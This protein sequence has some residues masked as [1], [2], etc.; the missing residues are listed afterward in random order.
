MSFDSADATLPGDASAPPGDS[1]TRGIGAG[2]RIGRYLLISQVGRGAVGVVFAAYDPELDRRVAIKLLRPGGEGS[3]ASSPQ[4]RLI[5][6]ARAMARLTH[7]N[8]VAI[9]DVGEHEGQVFIAMEFVRGRTLTEWMTEAHSWREAVDLLLGPASGL[10]AAHEQG[11]V[12]R[13]FKPD[14]VMIGDDGRARVLDLGLVRTV[15]TTDARPALRARS[16][17]DEYFPQDDVLGVDITRTGALVGTPRYMAPEQFGGGDVDARTDQFAYCLT[18]FEAI[19]GQRPFSGDSLGMLARKVIEGNIDWPR[20]DHVPRFIRQALQ[21]GLATAPEERFATMHELI[22]ALLNDPAQNRRRVIAGVG[23]VALG[24]AGFG[25]WQLH[26]ANEQAT[27]RR[28]ADAIDEVWNDDSRAE[29]REQLTKIEGQSA[30]AVTDRIV[31]ETD[32][33]ATAWSEARRQACRSEQGDGPVPQSLADRAAACLLEQRDDLSALHEAVTE[34]GA[35]GGASV[36]TLGT[37]PDPDDCLDTKRLADRVPPPADPNARVA[38]AEVRRRLTVADRVFDLGLW[39]RAEAIVAE[40]REEP[41]LE[42]SPALKARAAILLA[43][44]RRQQSDFEGA[45]RELML[46]M[47]FAI[48]ASDDEQTVRAALNL[49]SLLGALDKV[50]AGERW[51]QLADSIGARGRTPDASLLFAQQVRTRLYFASG[52]F[53]ASLT[54]AE[55]TIASLERLRG[56][57]YWSVGIA[58]LER[59]RALVRLGRLDEA[60]EA[61]EHALGQV[62]PQLGSRSLSVARLRTELGN[63]ELFRG[64]YQAASAAYGEAKRI[65]EAVLGAD[66]LQALTDVASLANIALLRGRN[67]EAITWFRT[68]LAGYEK[69]VGPHTTTA[70]IHHSLG[71][72]LHA[73]GQLGE[74]R[75]ELET[76]IEMLEGLGGNHQVDI[77]TTVLGLAEVTYDEGDPDRA[78]DLYQR[79]IEDLS[80]ATRPHSRTVL[81]ARLRLAKL[82]LRTGQPNAALEQ[83]RWVREGLDADPGSDGVVEAIAEAVRARAE[84]DLGRHDEGLRIGREALAKMRELSSI[85]EEEV[86]ALATWLS[87]PTNSSTG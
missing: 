11:L 52:D 63:A 55:A 27:C 39:K 67:E 80:A 17:D 26:E 79:A 58:Q 44:S 61:L 4:Q 49:A 7:P 82:E 10:A 50:D 74:A 37:P 87:Q 19:Y 20:S 65:H 45:E 30:P 81:E 62:E 41:V 70:N 24:V 9:H 48:R 25:G 28:H 42:H 68:A 18:L 32:R 78:R 6:E 86:Q 59:A 77:A 75:R 53:E 84:W 54:A 76:A 72:A 43:M 8:V 38:L 73:T 22:A 3:S 15:R 2:E 1:H 14:N 56:P 33:F 71:G 16:F 5:R 23:V 85:T 51:L 12:H 13:D 83:L 34:I 46:A 36:A 40:V 69:A 47:D 31:S 66:S 29:L 35:R 64:R 21:R 60:V 57:G